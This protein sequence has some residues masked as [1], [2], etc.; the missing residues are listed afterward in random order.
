MNNF[1]KLRIMYL[2]IIGSLILLIGI[3]ILIGYLVNI[4]SNNDTDYIREE[5]TYKI[6][7]NYDDYLLF[8][9]ESTISTSFNKPNNMEN[10][11]L[12][13]YKENKTEKELYYIFDNLNNNAT[14]LNYIN[15]YSDIEFM[16][17]YDDLIL[18]FNIFTNDHNNYLNVTCN[19]YNK[20]F[21]F[22]SI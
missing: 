19:Y 8:T 21:K 20:T 9:N 12:V 6:N 7:N 5:I 3:T 16:F 4:F 10:V 13:T 18:C 1:E 11:V 14:I 15:Y 2:I 22:N 17:K